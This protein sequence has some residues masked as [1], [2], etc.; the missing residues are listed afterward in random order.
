MLDGA[1]ESKLSVNAIDQMDYFLRQFFAVSRA[2]WY[3]LLAAVFIGALMGSMAIA[4][5]DAPVSSVWPYVVGG[6]MLGLCAGLLLLWVD[7]GRRCREL[8]GDGR[9]TMRER[10]LA[11]CVIVGCALGVLSVICGFI[12]AAE[13][14]LAF[15]RR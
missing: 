2:R 10:L 3:Q 14:M 5:A 1:R 13:R 8:R 11:G 6:A 7:A 9:P 12:V 15:L 4:E